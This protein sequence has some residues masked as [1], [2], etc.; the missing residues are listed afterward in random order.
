M[1]ANSLDWSLLQTF[2]VLA[3]TGSLNRAAPV[4]GQ[5]QPTLSRQLA[6]LEAALGQSLFERHARGLS[7]TPAGQALLPAAQRMREGAQELALA[8]SAQDQS[9]A[10]TVRLT[11][12][13]IVCAYFLPSVLSDLRQRHPEIQIELVASNEVENLLERSADIALRMVRPDQATLVA[14]KLGDW[15]VG[16]FAHQ[17]YLAR[18]GMPT[19]D[20]VLSHQWLGYDRNDQMLRGF[21][22]AGFAVQPDFF[23]FRCDNQVVVWEA[24]RAG[25]GLAVGALALAAREP[26]LVQVLPEIQ[27][28]ALP[29]W[30]TA[31]RELRDTPRLRL[32][33]DALAEA[34][35]A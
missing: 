5:S 14:R 33:F 12:S 28:P 29:M 31:H 7:L 13:E 3:E 34:F 16:V 23:G 4:L 26:D 8:L 11:A 21:A 35:S 10:G 19:M 9:L 27:I 17:D 2:L 22:A 32:V 25:M 30:L 24:M 20:T 18:H 6:A 15:P 1:R